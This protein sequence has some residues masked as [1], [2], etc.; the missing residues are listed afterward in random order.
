VSALIQPEG[1]PVRV[2]DVVLSGQANLLID[3]R[4]FTEH[5]DLWLRPEIG[6]A[7]DMVEDLLDFLLQSG[8]RICTV[9]ARVDL[10][11]AAD[12]LVTGISNTSR[13]PSVMASMSSARHPAS[14]VGT[15]ES[16]L[17]LNP[18]K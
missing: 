15:S 18:S 12:F 14:M 13:L 8:D 7:P 1:I 3:H 4:I 9:T 5:Q 16:R 11:D 2:L 10:V 17:S 6:F